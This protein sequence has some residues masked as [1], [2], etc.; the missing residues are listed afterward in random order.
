MTDYPEYSTFWEGQTANVDTNSSHGR[1]PYYENTTWGNGYLY[2]CTFENLQ[3][4]F[5]PK[6]LTKKVTENLKLRGNFN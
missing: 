3:N 4:C 1:S 2:G 6:W 5:V